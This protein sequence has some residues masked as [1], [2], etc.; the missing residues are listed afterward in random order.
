MVQLLIE[1]AK[2]RITKIEIVLGNAMRQF[3]DF[4]LMASRYP[5]L[6]GYLRILKHNSE[7]LFK[8]N[9]SG[10][11]IASTITACMHYLAEIKQCPT[12]SFNDSKRALIYIAEMIMTIYFDQFQAVFGRNSI[13]V[14]TSL[15]RFP[16]I[17]AIWKQLIL[18]PTTMGVLDLIRR[19]PE[20]W[21][22][23]NVLPL[24]TIRKFEFLHQ[25]SPE[26]TRPHFREFYK[27]MIGS[28]NDGSMKALCLRAFLNPSHVTDFQTMDIRAMNIANLLSSCK[29]QNE[30]YNFVEFQTCKMAFFFDWLGYDNFSPNLN[31]PLPIVTSWKALFQICTTNG[32]LLCSLYEF[33]ILLVQTLYPPLTPIFVK[34]VTR[35]FQCLSKNFPVASLLDS[36]KL[37]KPLRELFKETF[38]ELIVFFRK[39]NIPEVIPVIVSPMIE[40]VARQ[41]SVTSVVDPTEAAATTQKQMPEQS[42]PKKKPKKQQLEAPTLNDD[43]DFIPEINEAG[44]HSSLA[45]TIEAHV[46]LLS[47][48]IKEEFFKLENAIKDGDD[49]VGEIEDVCDAIIRNHEMLVENDE[50]KNSIADCFLVIFKK[51]FMTKE[52]YVPREDEK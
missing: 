6:L 39:P 35:I 18:S 2:W 40:K 52:F 5:L 31:L 17:A 23:S 29:S 11:L 13:L 36:T 42:K 25:N 24:T 49:G 1:M 8:S 41:I 43:H 16:E 51:F 37:E 3:M 4:G 33:L 21:L 47:D 30:S 19:P 45:E 27:N 26:L 10:L 22:E 46:F 12:S 20:Q 48:D 38:P 15:S 34:S 14:I 9:E 7:F 44:W 50:L 32:P 28:N